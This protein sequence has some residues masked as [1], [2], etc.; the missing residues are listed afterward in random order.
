MLATLAFALALQGAR[1]LWEPDEGRY[2]NVALE[3][4]ASGDWLTPRLHHQV[5]HFSKPPLTY[6]TIAASLELF[7]HNEWAAR[8]PGALAFAG[9]ILLVGWTARRL[10]P[11]A[12]VTAAIVYA[13]SLL[14]FVAANIVSTDTLL[15]FCALLGAAG[16]VELV[17]G[18]GSPRLSRAM[19]WGG[20]GLAFLTKGPPGLLPL[21]ALLVFAARERGSWRGARRLISLPSFA[22]FSAL[23]FT[24]YLHEIAHRPDLLRY[25][26]G[27]EVMER[28]GSAEFDRNSGLRG[29][30]R[31]YGPVAI[32]AMLPWWPL[33][34]LRGRRQGAATNAPRGARSREERLLLLWLLLPLTVFV[35]A[36]SRLPLYLLPLAAPAAL[37][38][39]R[40]LGPFPVTRRELAVVLTVAFLLVGLKG[41]GARWPSDRDGR[42]FASE[43]LRQL[44]YSPGEVLFVEA[45][46]HY[47]LAFY[48]GCEVEEVD[49]A[50]VQMMPRRP[51]YRPLE[52]PLAA[53]LAEDEPAR[54]YL[55]TPGG[56]EA[57]RR[58][59]AA[60]GYQTVPRG[61][62]GRY[63]I[64]LAPRPAHA[65]SSPPV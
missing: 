42:R 59:V 65:P 51:S 39:A 4:I 2:V 53:E 38:I 10:A 3:M 29:L 56:D 46:P 44:P 36:Q 35:V 16:F 30:F 22:L 43:L 21:A 20:F 19:L 34:L 23:A 40:R 47:T 57:W 11:G 9:T 27:A 54:V 63:T 52:E 24:W 50:T 15:V 48:L 28:V 1:P 25:L 8:L 55:V 5:P 13:T 49:L 6:W 26:L 62:V 14:P 45:R 18:D 60:L 37:L 7:G 32:A 64:Y 41:L 58:E 61:K 31:A 12:E 33:A 17:F